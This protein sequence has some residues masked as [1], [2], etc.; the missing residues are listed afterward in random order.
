[1]ST[2]ATEPA[3]AGFAVTPS[4][5]DQEPQPQ[6]APDTQPDEEG[7]EDAIAASADAGPDAETGKLFEVPRVGV[8]VDDA[9]PTVLKI[10]FSGSVEIERGDAAG[11]KFYNTLR[12]GR[13]VA[14]QVDA[15][16]ATTK[17]THRRDSEGDVDAVVQTK[18]LVIHSLENA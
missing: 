3:D 12:A 6:P 17:T 1:M 2:T 16:V 11:V 13:G 8:I 14:L 10:T 4:G 5:Q 18:S 15:H 7:E 9:D